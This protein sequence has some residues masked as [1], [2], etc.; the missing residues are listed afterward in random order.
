MK[1]SLV[2]LIAAFVLPTTVNAEIKNKTIISNI[3]NSCVE[4]D[5]YPNGIGYQY[6]YCGCFVNKVSKGMTYKEFLGLELEAQFE[7]DPRSQEKALLANQKIKSYIV[8]CL[9]STFEE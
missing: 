6:S 5:E 1:H 7:D 2:F 4:Q 8:D 9:S 3:F